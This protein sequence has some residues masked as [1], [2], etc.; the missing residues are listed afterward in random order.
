MYTNTRKEKSEVVVFPQT[1]EANRVINQ[2]DLLQNGYWVSL[3][4]TCRSNDPCW[5][6]KNKNEDTDPQHGLTIWFLTFLN[7]RS[8]SVFHRQALS[9]CSTAFLD[10]W[11]QHTVSQ[12][13]GCGTDGWPPFLTPYCSRQASISSGAWTCFCVGMPKISTS[14]PIWSWSN[15]S[16]WKQV[17]RG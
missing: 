3:D 5:H 6:R 17:F 15:G 12:T 9:C 7:Q 13:L 11:Q 16:A 10:I 14:N 2:N 1:Y 8:E 4:R